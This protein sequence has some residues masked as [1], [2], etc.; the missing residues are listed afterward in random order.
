MVVI[1]MM[2]GQVGKKNGLYIRPGAKDSLVE[3]KATQLEA[4]RSID[5]EEQLIVVLEIAV[6][7]HHINSS[8]LMQVCSL[9]IAAINGLLVITATIAAATTG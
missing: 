5:D 6:D 8:Q 4:K 3:G 2:L 1:V 9:L 7:S